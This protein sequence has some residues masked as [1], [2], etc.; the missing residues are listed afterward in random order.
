[1]AKTRRVGAA[2]LVCATVMS[3]TALF[4][5]DLR[6]ADK[7][8][9]I[10]RHMLFGNPDRAAVELSPDGTQISWLAAV[11]GVL[12]VWVAP[13]GDLPAARAVTHD[14]KRGIRRYFWS[15]TN[16]HILYMQDKGGDED[17]HIYSVDLKSGKEID[18]TPYKKVAAQV[19]EV[20]RYFPE[21]ILVGINNRDPRHHDVHR[22]NIKT[23]KSSLVQQNDEGYIGYITDDD[24][25]VY[26]AVKMTKDG[27]SEIFRKTGE[28]SWSSFTKIG[29]D[30][31]LTTSPLGLDKSRKNLFM[32]DSRGRNT[33]AL[34]KLN[35]D[36][37]QSQV[38]AQ[39]PRADISGIMMHPTEKRVQA[40]QSTFERRRW[41]ILDK[42]IEGDLKYLKTVAD[43]ELNITSRTLDDNHW[44]V[45]YEM[46]NGPVR[47]YLYDRKAGKAKFLFTNRPALDSVKLAKMHPVTIKA[48][49]GLDLV[50]YFTLPT[51]TDPDANGRPSEPLPMVL[52]VHGGPWGRDNWGFHPYHQWLANRGYAVLS[53]NFRGSTGFGKDF[54]N[55]G[56]FEWA[57]KMH[58]D[59]LDAVDW[60]VA[61]KIADKDRVAIMGG[62]YGG[63]AT[64]VGLTFTPTKFACGV[65]I[66]GPSNI[67]T[68][69]NTIPEYWQP[70]IELFASRVGDHRTEEG[71][72]LL[73]E[74]SPL[75]H[76]DKIVRP[77]L[78]GQGANDPRVKQSESDQ[79]VAAM[80]K[81]N[82]PVTY[83][84]YPDEG[85]GFARP[86]NR[87]SFNA[88]AEGF[89]A[90][91]L[92]GRFQP[93]SEDMAGSSI[94]VPEGAAGV[95]GL[96]RVIEARNKASVDPT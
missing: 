87:M 50:S 84:L 88:V 91:H 3:M 33:A 23:G 26:F 71:R 9:L 72:A 21:E 24:M 80:K 43:G 2:V 69:I 70:M 45:V 89:L 82:I 11:D 63:Y 95:K 57:G 56:N 46:D 35:I 49:D 32:L 28:N 10:P 86:E 44:I 1:M 5:N 7:T 34:T 27:G 18:L 41:Q 47:Y 36:S 59:L 51:W 16:N 31:S 55:A 73:N 76:V 64:L 58:D 79:I 66:V 13:A 68:L 38:L 53:V 78:I 62:S 52:F 25:N 60:A 90:E 54:I 8:P 81:K 17:W 94:T 92:G 15:Y 20:S 6:A 22:V 61:Q 12:N 85:H 39:D 74:R 37:M 4:T 30:D 75:T 77:L 42:S 14:E 19:V 67:L 65:D 83:V 40:V 29:P 96:S 93:M 48:R